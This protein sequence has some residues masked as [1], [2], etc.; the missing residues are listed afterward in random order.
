[1]KW[2]F[3]STSYFNQKKKYTCYQYNI[4]QIQIRATWQQETYKFGWDIQIWV[5]HTN[6]RPAVNML[7]EHTSSCRVVVKQS[8]KHKSSTF[9]FS[10]LLTS[11]DLCLS[12][13]CSINFLTTW[14]L[15]SVWA[16]ALIKKEALTSHDYL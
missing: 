12:A 4:N 5:K 8:N 6:Y 15:A 1:M 16:N 11:G 13:Q 9:H 10:Q 14:R 3:V 2:F 7:T